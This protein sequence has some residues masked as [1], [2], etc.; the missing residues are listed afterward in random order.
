MSSLWDSVDASGKTSQEGEH[1]AD[2]APLQKELEGQRL[3]PECQRLPAVTHLGFLTGLAGR[4][5]RGAVQLL[6]DHAQEL[7]LV[8]AP[9]V[10]G[11]ADADQ[12]GGEKGS[13]MG[14][15]AAQAQPS[16]WQGHSSP[17]A[18]AGDTQHSLWPRGFF[19]FFF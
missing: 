11:R 15:S 18:H 17:G 2:K 5:V 9:V 8:F 10:V 3:G 14:A 6:G 12:L 16:R 4:A 7:S 1:K 19:F 13:T